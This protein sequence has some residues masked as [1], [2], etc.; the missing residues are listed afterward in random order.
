MLLI[1]IDCDLDMFFTRE[2]FRIIWYYQTILLPPQALE[3]HD[4]QAGLNNT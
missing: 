4:L 1:K 3:K 2:E